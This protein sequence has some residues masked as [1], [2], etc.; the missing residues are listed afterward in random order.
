MVTCGCPKYS[1]S[2]PESQVTEA[3]L[4]AA[5][6]ALREAMVGELKAEF[7]VQRANQLI[8]DQELD[9]TATASSISKAKKTLREARFSELL[10]RGTVKRLVHYVEKQERAM[11]AKVNAAATGGS[12]AD[13]EPAEN[14]G[15]E[16]VVYEMQ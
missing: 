14:G 1:H 10:A 9:K 15:E 5:R 2:M 16:D 11:A 12:G 7:T 13:A 8:L 3:T 6:K 4:E